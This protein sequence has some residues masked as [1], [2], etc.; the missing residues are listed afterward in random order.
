MAIEW[1]ERYGIWSARV[2]W[3]EI[4]VLWQGGQWLA[5]CAAPP[6]RQGVGKGSLEG[7]QAEALRLLENALFG[8]AKALIAAREAAK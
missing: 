1:T 5:H 3:A 6:I 4:L 8:P 2:E 7:A